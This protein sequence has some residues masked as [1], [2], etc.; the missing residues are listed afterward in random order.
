MPAHIKEEGIILHP[1]IEEGRRISGHVLKSALIFIYILYVV[2]EEIDISSWK[3][4][5]NIKQNNR[6]QFDWLLNS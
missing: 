2:N 5:G 6:N 3:K 4:R 1:L